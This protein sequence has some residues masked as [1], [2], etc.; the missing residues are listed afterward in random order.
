MIIKSKVDLRRG[1]SVFQGQD[2]SIAGE[3]NYG[4]ILR[5]D[6]LSIS[7]QLECRGLRHNL[8]VK[9]R[10]DNILIG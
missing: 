8:Q 6:Q 4:G 9:E 10:V 2:N 7:I 5:D 3:V 1:S